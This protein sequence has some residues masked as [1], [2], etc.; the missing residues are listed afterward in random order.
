M[1]VL[2]IVEIEV[3]GKRTSCLVLRVVDLGIHLF[4]AA[5]QKLDEHVVAPSV[6][7]VHVDAAG[8]AR[9]HQGMNRS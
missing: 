5:P 8:V 9:A 3:L 6:P 2:M 1:A 7:A 4:G